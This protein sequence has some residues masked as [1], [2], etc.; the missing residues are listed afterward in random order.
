MLFS[1]SNDPFVITVG[2]VDVDGDSGTG[3]DVNAPWSAY[4]YTVDGFAK[5]IVVSGAPAPRGPWHPAQ[6]AL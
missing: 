2:A 5:P 4:G 3:N 6:P 1:P